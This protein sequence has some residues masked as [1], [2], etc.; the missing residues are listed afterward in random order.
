MLKIL[1]DHRSSNRDFNIILSEKTSKE[2]GFFHLLLLVAL[3]VI[4]DGLRG[5]CNVRTSFKLHQLHLSKKSKKSNESKGFGKK[6]ELP[7]IDDI[8][9]PRDADGNVVSVEDP[10]STSLS[11]NSMGSSTSTTSTTNVKDDDVDAL[12]KKYGIKDNTSDKKKIITKTK[13]GKLSTKLAP[14]EYDPDRPFGEA[15]LAGISP[16]LQTKIDN[17][18]VTGTFAALLFVVLCGVGISAGALQIVFPN[19]EISPDVD[20][21]IKNFLT[22]SFTPSL[23]IFF[24]FSITFGLFKFAQISSSQTVYRE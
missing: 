6:A 12:F 11:T 20:A 2:M 17:I 4:V 5:Y 22:P 9:V 14:K 18:L 16:Q 7:V 23:G 21:L 19:I 15:V 13:D 10:N 24:F 1:F 3:L 8:K